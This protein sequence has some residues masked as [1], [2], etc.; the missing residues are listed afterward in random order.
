VWL[1]RHLLRGVLGE[2]D[3]TWDIPLTIRGKPD[4]STIR[5]NLIVLSGVCWQRTYGTEAV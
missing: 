3:N 1:H 2:D 5:G 4:C